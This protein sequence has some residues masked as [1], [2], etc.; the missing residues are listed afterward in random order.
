M[1]PLEIGGLSVSQQVLVVVCARLDPVLSGMT[2]RVTQ[3]VE[4]EL[5]SE[6]LSLQE[7]CSQ[8]L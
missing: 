1:H 4:A 8:V 6:A 5:L 3:D 7:Q 2:V